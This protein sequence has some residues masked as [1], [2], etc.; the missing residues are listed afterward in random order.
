MIVFRKPLHLP[1]LLGGAAGAFLIGRKRL[2]DFYFS[3]YAY[4]MARGQLAVNSLDIARTNVPFGGGFGTFG[5][6]AAQT[7]YSPL[8]Y[9]YYMMTTPGLTPKYP[10][11]ACDTFFPAILGETGWTGMIAYAGM[12][13]LL[14]VM[15]LRDQKSAVAGERSRHALFAGI[16]LLAFELLEATGTLSF[17]E[18]YSVLISMAL[19]LA[20][21]C[22]RQMSG[23]P[24]H[25]P[26]EG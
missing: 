23:S 3:P 2:Y 14:A 7:F 8:Y 4:T 9:K 1:I 16:L 12:I 26:A 21:V 20:I 17:S 15:I 10:Y 24:Q 18:H 22:S 5:S 19:A 13:V 6:R 11:F 25:A